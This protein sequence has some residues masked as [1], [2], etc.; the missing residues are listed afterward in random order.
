MIMRTTDPGPSH[1]RRRGLRYH[2]SGLDYALAEQLE[3][4]L[5]VQGCRAAVSPRAAD[6]VFCP[7]NSQ[8]L[9]PA[10]SQAGGRPV[11][12]VSRLPETALWLDAL[13][14]GATDYYAAPFEDH[15][16]GWILDRHC[17]RRSAAA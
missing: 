8:D 3:S 6:I 12:A 5:Q 2:F 15:H 10:L 9:K 14:A 17:R 13:E 16:I 7:A 1:H 4:A 11:I